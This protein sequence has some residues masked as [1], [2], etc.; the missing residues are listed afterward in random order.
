MNRWIHRQNWSCLFLTHYWPA[1]VRCYIT[2]KG[3]MSLSLW[4]ECWLCYSVQ[5]EWRSG[6]TSSISL[7][8]LGSGPE[9]AA[10][11]NLRSDTQ[12]VCHS[13]LNARIQSKHFSLKWKERNEAKEKNPG[14]HMFKP[15]QCSPTLLCLWYTDVFFRQVSSFYP[16]ICLIRLQDFHL[17]PGVYCLCAYVS[18]AKFMSICLVKQL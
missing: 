4:R 15:H 17:A 10:Q 14:G 2:C 11:L 8:F 13:C 9:Q 3:D 7:L 6:A 5:G 16:P 18:P 1:S 12:A